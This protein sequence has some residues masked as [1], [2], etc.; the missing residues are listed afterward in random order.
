VKSIANRGWKWFSSA[1]VAT[2]AWTL[3]VV[4]V[5]VAATS[6]TITSAVAETD[7]PSESSHAVAGSPQGM[8]G[9]GS[10]SMSATGSGSSSSSTMPSMAGGDGSSS[11]MPSMSQ[12]SNSAADAGDICP[13]VTGGSVM[14]NGMEMA[15]VPSGAPTAAQRAAAEQLVSETSADIQK[16]SSLSAA[17][18]AGYMPIT[19]GKGPMTHYANWSLV[20]PDNVLNPEAPPSL[21]YANTVDGPVLIGAMYFGPEPCQPGPDIGGPLTDW[22]AHS[23]LCVDS[24]HQVVGNTDATGGCANGVHN[25]Q[26]LFM[27]HVWTAPQLAAQYQFQADL[28]PGALSQIVRTG[29]P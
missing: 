3:C 23:N 24:Q 12:G 28:P 21:M 16:Y 22:H 27:L 15:P 11:T 7:H 20:R 17:E 8:S 29:Q 25:T 19:P 1:S 13:N 4:T 14:P 10:G 9:E 26:T 2:K 5:A 18:A 6:L